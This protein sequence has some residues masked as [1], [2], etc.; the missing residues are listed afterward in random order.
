MHVFV[1]AR[2]APAVSKALPVGGLVIGAAVAGL[3]LSFVVPLRG[4]ASRKPPARAS[5]T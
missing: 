5:I 3:V 4:G 2:M 1:L